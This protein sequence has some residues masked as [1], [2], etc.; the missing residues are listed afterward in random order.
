MRLSRGTALIVK[1]YAK[2]NLYLEVVNKR[3]DNYHN[4][5]TLFERISLCDK[6]VLSPLP[7]KQIKIISNSK[8]L[9]TDSSNLAYKSALLLQDKFKLDK[10]V[11]ITITKN[12]PI[13]AG[14]GGGSSNAAAVLKAL[15]TLWGLNLSQ[16]SLLEHARQIG[17]DVAFFIYN[18]PYASGAGRGE[19]IS[20]LRNFNNL[21]LWHVLAV[22]KIMVSTPLIYRKWDEDEKLTKPGLGVKLLYSA[23]RKKSLTFP[24]DVLFN[25]LEQVTIALYPEVKRIKNKLLGLGIEAVSMSGSGPAVFG[26]ASTRKEAFKVSTQL[27]DEDASWQVFTT[28][29][30]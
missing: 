11:K 25:G 27:K 5:K 13:G 9:P 7:N 23:L 21:K 6:I 1:S 3:K 20:P 22:P 12:I 29:T 28:C 15:N 4:I 26:I 10:G 16:Q 19:R 30:V 17:S 18:T 24:G 14:L 2:V 8:Y